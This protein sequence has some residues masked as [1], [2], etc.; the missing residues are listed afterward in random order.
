SPTPTWKNTRH[1]PKTK[2]QMA[3]TYHGTYVRPVGDVVSGR[4]AGGRRARVWR[5]ALDN[6]EG[7]LEHHRDSSGLRRDHPRRSYAVASILVTTLRHLS[8]LEST[9]PRAYNPS[10]TVG[11]RP[12][13]ATRRL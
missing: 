11:P 3:T 5:L 10:Q 7:G 2:Q 8:A 13:H 1:I 6:D 9:R 12:W 4:R